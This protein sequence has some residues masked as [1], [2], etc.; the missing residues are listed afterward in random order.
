M[1][2]LN[3]KKLIRTIQSEAPFAKSAKDQFYYHSRRLLRRPHERDF[4]ALS[5]IPDDLPGCWLDIGA[6]HGQSIESIRLF[7]PGARVLS[8]E[9]NPV[10]ARKL[11]DRYRQDDLVRI[12]DFGL[13]DQVSQFNLYVPVYNGFL[14]DGLASF[15]REKARG[16]LGPD[17][18]YWFR[19]ERLQIRELHCRARPLDEMNLDPVFAKIDVQGYEYAVLAGARQTLEKYEPILLV[20]DIDLEPRIRRLVEDFGYESYFFDGV[21]LQRGASPTQ[22]TFLLTP[23]RF[24]QIGARTRKAAGRSGSMRETAPGGK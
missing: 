15:D 14:Y 16:W 17:T 24:S 9:P 21:S 8:F 1:S 18:L 12:F 6:N 2:K 23:R 19:P 10:L 3:L 5:L 11:W 7:K 4:Y 20:E 22:N 13:A